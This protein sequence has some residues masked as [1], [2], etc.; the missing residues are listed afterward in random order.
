MSTS[1]GLATLTPVP[2]PEG[3]AATVHFAWPGGEYFLL[4][5]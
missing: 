4:G 1:Y 5:T 2:F 3:Y